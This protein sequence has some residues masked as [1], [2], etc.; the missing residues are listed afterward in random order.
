[1]AKVKSNKVKIIRRN[2]QL[3]TLLLTEQNRRIQ[4]SERL[5]KQQLRYGMY[6]VIEDR[7]RPHGA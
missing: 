3:I 2:G 7:T 6:Q 4:I 5:F 1:M